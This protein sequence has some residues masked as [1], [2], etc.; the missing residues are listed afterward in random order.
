M[1]AGLG[2]EAAGDGSLPRVGSDDAEPILVE[3][4]PEP[5]GT[6]EPVDVDTLPDIVGPGEE[7]DLRGRLGV[8]RFVGAAVRWAVLACVAGVAA[9]VGA[10]LF[11]AGLNL[12]IGWVN[13]L[14]SAIPWWLIFLFPPV[15]G[16]RG[17]LSAV[18]DG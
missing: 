7:L 13:D 15:G 6:D 3:D 11:I 14:R 16:F 9:G 17:R 4:P 2:A 12:L 5:I 10:S 1:T 18:A 8:R